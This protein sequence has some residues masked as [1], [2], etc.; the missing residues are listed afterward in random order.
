MHGCTLLG[1]CC[2]ASSDGAR[3]QGQAVRASRN[4]HVYL[5]PFRYVYMQYHGLPQDRQWVIPHWTGNY[6]V[7][8][9]QLGGLTALEQQ[10]TQRFLFVLLH[11]A[12]NGNAPALSVLREIHG[13]LYPEAHDAFIPAF[14]AA[15]DAETA[16]RIGEAV[17]RA[18]S[19]GQLAIVADARP[20]MHVAPKP[21][22]PALGPSEG[23]ASE[24]AHYIELELVDQD[25]KPVGGESYIV[26]LPDGGTRTGR[27]DSNGRASVTGI[28]DPGS[29]QVSF[30]NLDVSVWA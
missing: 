27:L 21:L 25:E 17:E 10:S 5:T 19:T 9:S 2:N 12:R 7:R 6:V 18:A 28:K 16:W 20:V 30:P 14:G 15:R 4:W 24:P 8:V 29:C 13:A 23:A 22:D 26:K 3:L 11:D 1:R